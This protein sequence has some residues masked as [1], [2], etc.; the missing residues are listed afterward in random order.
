MSSNHRSRS[1]IIGSSTPTTLASEDS[2]VRGLIGKRTR[3]RGLASEL[4]VLA[5][6][7]ALGLATRS[8]S[9]AA[10]VTPFS[11]ATLNSLYENHGDYV[12]KVVQET[13]DLVD[14]RFWLKPDGQ[15]VKT[16]AA[17]AGVP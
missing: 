14:G 4:V 12:R 17:Q 13:N 7:L 11:D 2:A 10:D 5:L 9:A 1:G 16:D 8:E 6:V 15:T 3:E